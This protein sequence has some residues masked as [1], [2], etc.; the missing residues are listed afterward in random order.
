MRKLLFLVVPL[1]LPACAAATSAPQVLPGPVTY[2]VR[3]WGRIMVRW[4]VNPDGTGE[5]WRGGQGRASA[6]RKFRL[7]LEG[8]AL[9]TF[10]ANVEDARHATRDGVSCRKEI[11]DL[12]YGS[13]TWDYPTAKQAYSFDAGCR[14]EKGDEVQDILTA[15]SSN[16]ETLAN[17]EAK[18]YIVEPVTQR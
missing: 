16:V 15:A 18:P 11:F 10:V 14:S 13:I 2:E 9:R 8:D 3:S 12:P 17:I 1:A 5:I 6:L 7:K 4:Q